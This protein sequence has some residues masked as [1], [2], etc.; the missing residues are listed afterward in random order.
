MLLIRRSI[1]LVV[2]LTFFLSATGLAQA[3]S[4][5]SAPSASVSTDDTM[6]AGQ[7]DGEMLAEGLGTGGKLGAGLGIGVLTG[8]IGTAIGYFVIGSEP[9][10]AE[11][12]KRSL[13]KSE[14]YQ[15]GFKTGWDR[16]TKSKKRNAFL[17]GGLIG[18]AAFVALVAAAQSNTN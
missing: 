18:T 14:D 15:L 5:P 3:Q 13:G 1:A 6:A 11:A 17:A 8:V 2:A 4:A 16:K 10:S 12:L 7:R 9:L